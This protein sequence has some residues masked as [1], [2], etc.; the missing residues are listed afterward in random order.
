M[1]RLGP[2]LIILL[3]VAVLQGE[4]YSQ[5]L[6]A[7]TGDGRQVILKSD[8]TWKFMDSEPSGENSGTYQKS[9]SAK[10]VY[11]IKGGKAAFFFD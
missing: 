3:V 10:S 6:R 4:A 9:E 2:A 5:D 7:K 11:N 8:G 1:T